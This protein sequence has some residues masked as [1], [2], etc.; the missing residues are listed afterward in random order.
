ME[1]LKI[2]LHYGNILYDRI[3]EKDNVR[4]RI[5]K[6]NNVLYYTEQ[7]PKYET[8]FNLELMAKCNKIKWEK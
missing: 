8:V 3:F 4:I 1:D 6:W 2:L 5:I 7:N